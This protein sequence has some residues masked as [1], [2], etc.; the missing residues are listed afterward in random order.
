LRIII[1]II[2]IIKLLLLLLRCIECECST[3]FWVLLGRLHWNDNHKVQQFHS[4][5]R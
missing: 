1:I 5:I 4:V 3:A 2:F